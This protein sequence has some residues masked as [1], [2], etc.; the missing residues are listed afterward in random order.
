MLPGRRLRCAVP[1]CPRTVAAARLPADDTEWV[2]GAHWAMTSAA[3][4]RRYFALRRR[5]FRTPERKLAERRRMVDLG[6]AMWDRLR[7]QAIE[8]AVGISG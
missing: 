2:C 1:H 7:D 6:H 4:R 3:W 5:F 8:R